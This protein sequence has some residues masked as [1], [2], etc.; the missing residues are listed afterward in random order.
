MHQGF[1]AA[2]GGGSCDA[3]GR[4][5]LRTTAAIPASAFELPALRSCSPLRLR[6]PES[7]VLVRQPV[8]KI[9]RRMRTA[10]CAAAVRGV[11]PAVPRLGAA[12]AP[13]APQVVSLPAA[14]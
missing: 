5:G 10:D 2:V 14:A 6:A 11:D 7:E 4:D 1:E 9:I 12:A 13:G 8:L 3:G